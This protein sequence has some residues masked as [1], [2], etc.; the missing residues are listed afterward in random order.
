[1][2]ENFRPQEEMGNMVLTETTQLSRSEVSKSEHKSLAP[3]HAYMFGTEPL[4]R[5]RR[6]KSKYVGM[7]K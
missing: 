1:M 6:L 5:G 3:I 4:R 2:L 7:A